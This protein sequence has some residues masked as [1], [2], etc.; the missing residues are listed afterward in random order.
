MELIEAQGRA[1]RSLVLKQQVRLSI[2]FL[3]ELST[4]PTTGTPREELASAELPCY[5]QYTVPIHR[6]VIAPNSNK[7]SRHIFHILAAK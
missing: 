3:P 2:D 1:V 6:T 5:R 7:V 4:L